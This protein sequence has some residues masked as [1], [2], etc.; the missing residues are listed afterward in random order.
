MALHN[1]NPAK[2]RTLQDSIDAAQ[3]D[4]LAV[5]V[6]KSAPQAISTSTP[7][8]LTWEVADYDSGGWF[9]S[10][11]D[12]FLTVPPGVSRVR[13]SAGTKWAG[14]AGTFKE[15]L[16]LKNGASAPGTSA[17]NLAAV[18]NELPLVSPV[19]E[20]VPGDKFTV[21]VRHDQ[22]IAINISAVDTTYF[23]VEA[24]R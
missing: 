12:T 7:T 20:V 14:T 22:G 11:G 1:L 2:H 21:S 13:L 24:V 8:L 9:A 5:L 15:M 10:S 19:I 23:S 3:D 18:T 6:S 4:F 17:I 16:F